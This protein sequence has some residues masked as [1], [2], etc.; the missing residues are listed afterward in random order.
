MKSSLAALQESQVESPHLENRSAF[1]QRNRRLRGRIAS[2]EPK[3]SDPSSGINLQ[4]SRPMITLG[5]L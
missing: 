2:E 4:A 5:I 3:A 1:C